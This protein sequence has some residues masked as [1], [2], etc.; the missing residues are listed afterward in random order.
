MSF[1]DA[2]THFFGEWNY[3]HQTED[4]NTWSS[5]LRK[6]TP[7]YL[8]FRVFSHLLSANKDSLTAIELVWPAVI[9]V[10]WKTECV[11]IW[12]DFNSHRT[13]LG[14][15]MADVTSREGVYI[16]IWRNL[17]TVG[18]LGIPS[19]QALLGIFGGSRGRSAR[20]PCLPICLC[21][22]RAFPWSSLRCD[23]RREAP[24]YEAGGRRYQLSTETVVGGR[25]RTL[26][27]S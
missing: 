11:Y 5:L 1:D 18:P 17:L 24:G 14:P 20:S 23:H 15:N 26:K 8:L 22:F 19:S 9:H 2:L 4:T 6:R 27:V 21:A 7:F 13:A 12:K 25:G 10:Y 16:A 3:V